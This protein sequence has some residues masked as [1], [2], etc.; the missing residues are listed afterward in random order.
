MYE[1]YSHLSSVFIKN[2]GVKAVMKTSVLL[3]WE[4]PEA[5]K[6][7]IQLKILY[8]HQNVEVQGILKKKLITQLQPFT[9][10]TFML[11]SHGTGAGGLQ[12]QVSIRTAPNLLSVK[13]T[14]YQHYVD[15]DRVAI[16]LPEVPTEAHV[17]SVLFVCVENRLKNP[18]SL[19]CFKNT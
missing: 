13:P 5:Y 3:T 6:S 19:F 16:N 9:Y 17:R 14:Q 2:F 8:N 7:E 1:N 11:M 15:E 12:Q 10:Y 18:D 4:V